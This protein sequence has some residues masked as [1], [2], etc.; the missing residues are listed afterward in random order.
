MYKQILKKEKPSAFRFFARNA[1]TGR[2]MFLSVTLAF[3][4]FT[5]PLPKFRF[6]A[7]DA[8]FSVEAQYES[9]LS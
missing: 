5:L 3:Q 8:L 7:F 9:P 1:E 4:P 6:H 2:T